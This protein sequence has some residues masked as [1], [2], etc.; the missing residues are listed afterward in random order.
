MAETMP[1]VTAAEL[2][3][4]LGN[5]SF[6]VYLYVGGE[7]DKGWEIAQIVYGMI[8][9]LRIY[10][11][12][13]VSMIE[14]WTKDRHHRGIVFGW[15][16]DPKAFLSLAQAEDLVFVMGQVNAARG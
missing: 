8:P 3:V 14:E 5:T 1:P 15:G 11:V 13:N 2:K 9:R 6:S 12:K 16:P 7:Q 10:L 4:Y